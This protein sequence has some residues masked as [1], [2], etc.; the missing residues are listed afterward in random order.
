MTQTLRLLARSS[1]IGIIVLAIWFSSQVQND[2]DLCM[3]HIVTVYSRYHIWVLYYIDRSIKYVCPYS[4]CVLRGLCMTQTLCLLAR[5]SLIGIN[6]LAIW[7]SRLKMIM[8][9]ACS[10]LLLYTVDT[11]YGHA[12][13]AS[14]PTP[15]DQQ[16]AQNQ[17]LSV[18]VYVHTF[19][20]TSPL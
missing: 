14:Q 1:L 13:T 19:P 7:F 18:G 2:Y 17:H 11:I 6:V 15:C 3:Q 9:Y 10:T 16:L 5:S 8:I 20:L 4:M 12:F